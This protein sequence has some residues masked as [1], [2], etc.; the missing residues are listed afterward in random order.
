M[1]KPERIAAQVVLSLLG[2]AVLFYGGVL[3]VSPPETT[4]TKRTQTFAGGAEPRQTVVE[5]TEQ[6]AS[7]ALVGT[8]FGVGAALLLT[9]L[10]LPRIQSVKS[11]VLEV[12]FGMD[13]TKPTDDERRKIAARAA[14]V[15]G[16]TADPEDVATLALAPGDAARPGSE[17]TAAASSSPAPAAGGTGSVPPRRPCCWPSRGR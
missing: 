4:L 3:V 6:K 1:S 15:L 11:G 17:R 12:T 8:I 5:T 10:V 9:G 16:R 2:A 14:A 7:D 13:A